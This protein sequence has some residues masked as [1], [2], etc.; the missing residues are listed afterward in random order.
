VA[1]PKEK[2]RSRAKES[3]ADY[4]AKRD[5]ARTPEPKGETA[6]P[7]G[8]LRFVVQRHRARRLHYDVRF[9]VDGV[10]ASWAVPRGPTLDPGARRLAVHVEDHPIEYVDFEGVIPH[11]E[12]GGGDVI[13]WDRGRWEPYGTDD[14]ARAIADG[15]LHADVWGE[16]LCGRFVLVRTGTD[17]SGKEQW[18]MFHKRD[19]CAREGWDPEAFPRSV[20]SGRTNDEV[21]AEPDAEWRSDLPAE[22]AES[23][24]RWD[25]PTADEL[26]ALDA[27]GAKGSW[28]FD[29]QTLRLT[30]L[31]K[32]LFP[33]RDGGPPFS[34]RDLIRYYASVAPV[35]LP[36]L[37]D[38]PVN[39]RRYPDGVDKPGF[40]QKAVPSHAPDWV[41][42]WRNEDADPGE[43]EWY[44]VADR[45]ATMAW[46]A[47][48][49]AVE[50][51]PWTSRCDRPALPTYAL[52]DIDPGPETTFDDVLVLARLY[53]SAL[54]HLGVVGRAKV[55]GR[56][57]LQIWVPVAPGP[58]FD[59]TRG[60]VEK[61]SRAVGDTVP[62]LVSWEWRVR[63]REGR[64]RLDYTQNAINKTLVAP[65]SVRATAGAPVSVPLEWDE[66]DDPDLRPD[67]WTISTAP[68][69]IAAVGDPFKV[70]LTALQRLP[71]L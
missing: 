14:P 59:Q 66:L 21:A 53:G 46:L 45:P 3:L 60:W 68:E 20:K 34:K 41:T 15:E 65:Y 47:N 48:Y 44:V 32:V 35:M 2:Q 9:E 22:I 70:L 4:H 16:K 49:G 50:L 56:R 19:E 5:F 23:R 37:H 1:R 58:S 28:E 12:Y 62:E 63:E 17:P 8:Q 61:V 39:T 25:P 29:G 13:V 64:A 18:L 71:N 69:R 33:R 36:Y 67:G 55:S 31:D 27:L 10:L 7:D 38:R 40:W 26:A 24:L 42:R 54:D 51:H 30:N 6:A 11:G 52:I 57:G 43:T